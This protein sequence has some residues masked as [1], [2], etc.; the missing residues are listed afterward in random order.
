[1]PNNLMELLTDPRFGKL[2]QQDQEDLIAG[3][4]Q[5]GPDAD[6][7]MEK[8][9]P[10]NPEA[11][12]KFSRLG[13]AE[14]G[15]IVGGPLGG[16]LGLNFPA[17]SKG[18][19]ASML[20]TGG[21]GT[22]AAPLVNKAKSSIGK[23][24]I[25]G[26]LGFLN[27]QLGTAT[28]EGVD[29]IGAPD[30]REKGSFVSDPATTR[31]AAGTA[32]STVLPM[33]LQSLIGNK[34]SNNPM[35][36]SKDMVS[37]LQAPQ[38]M[39]AM[40][41]M[42]SARPS[43]TAGL[44]EARVAGGTQP[45]SVVPVAADLATKEAQMAANTQRKASLTEANKYLDVNKS[46][47]AL[48]KA[49]ISLAS[50]NI[51]ADLEKQTNEIQS[52]IDQI[53][54]TGAGETEP[55]LLEARAKLKELAKVNNTSYVKQK[56][57][58]TV[59]QLE[60]QMQQQKAE[61]VRKGAEANA[62]TSAVSINLGQNKNKAGQADLG[63]AMSTKAQKTNSLT[64]QGIDNQNALLKQQ[65]ADLKIESDKRWNAMDAGL[66]GLSQD[67]N[68][69][70]QLV[71]SLVKAKSETVQAYMEHLRSQPQGSTHEKAIQDAL[72]SEFFRQAYDPATK[73]LS[74]TGK[75]TSSEGTFSRPKLDAIFGKD[76]AG[77][78]QNYVN[79]INEL[80]SSANNG[81][82]Q[83]MAH[84][85]KNHLFWIIPTGLL[86]NTGAMHSP[87][88]LATGTVASLATIAYPKIINALLKSPATADE[89]HRFATQGGLSKVSL[90]N[91]PRVAA[92]F[93]KESEPV[94]DEEI[95]SIKSKFTTSQSAGA[96]NVGLTPKP[97][98]QPPPPQQ[99]PAPPQ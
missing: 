45:P 66:R 68:N 67:V 58:N 81:N 95:N 59:D 53:K 1:M 73:I 41:S 8:H 20:V 24:G 48:R 19:L 31:G 86:Y 32:M 22:A 54:A 26:L 38:P 94:T 37:E 12:D 35:V 91:F 50:N 83:Q 71:E 63:K 7:M 80:V 15:S 98:M 18:D 82:L 9:A 76:T 40:D 17:K 65:I 51:K 6:K 30:D 89:F 62:A 70:Q 36:K 13:T 96:P 5:K 72:Q 33:L 74:N 34:V 88:A 69:P 99:A 11:L 44:E 21:A 29:R 64:A 75:L 42:A 87:E 27:H 25:T 56:A 77:K 16:L 79:E 47:Q 49:R 28:T 84:S 92:L 46:G 43:M 78:I 39:S 93:K 14:T 23:T 85:F 57:E 3:L 60:M 10:V 4:P 97:S 55:A 2:S 61:I 52:Q 90:S